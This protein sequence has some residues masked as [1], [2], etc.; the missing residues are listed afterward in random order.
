[1]PDFTHPFPHRNAAVKPECSESL[2]CVSCF[3]DDVDCNGAERGL[4]IRGEVFLDHLD[5]RAAVPSS[6]VDVGTLHRAEAV[7]CIPH[8]V[9]CTRSAF[10]V[11]TKLLFVE[12]SFEQL[13]LPL[14]ENEIG[15]IGGVPIVRPDSQR[16]P[17]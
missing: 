8:T 13:A 3:S 11:E 4:D 10:S 14:R 2:S 17:T 9:G 16:L 12:D 7:I 15:E 5:A 1:M 6:L